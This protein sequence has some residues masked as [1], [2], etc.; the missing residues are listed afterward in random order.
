MQL[1]AVNLVRPS[2]A[3]MRQWSNIIGSD[4]GLSPGRCQAINQT[5]AGILSIGPLGTNFS[6]ILI[7]I[8]D[9]MELKISPAKCRLFRL[10]LDVLSSGVRLNMNMPSYQYRNSHY[11]DNTSHD[12]LI[13]K[14]KIP[15]PRKTVFISR[16]DPGPVC[17]L[18][19]WSSLC[20]RMLGHQHTLYANQ[21][22]DNI[23]ICLWL[24]MISNTLSLIKLYK[25]ELDT[26]RVCST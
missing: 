23:S 1:T 2:D 20:F 16:P 14:M 9:K 7:E 8:R 17:I 18:N 5:N 22:S 21:T 6:E 19:Q 12:R 26:Q 24:S 13:C 10:G 4:N 3:Y 15:I 11:K 25:N